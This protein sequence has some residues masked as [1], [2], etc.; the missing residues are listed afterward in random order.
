MCIRDRDYTACGTNGR[1][2]LSGKSVALAATFTYALTPIHVSNVNTS[3]VNLTN[4]VDI[5]RNYD[6]EATALLTTQ[7][8]ANKY[9]AEEIAKKA[10]VVTLTQAEYDALADVDEDTLYLITPL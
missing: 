7:E 5:V 4:P 3:D 8:D 2:I 1:S 6:P 10:S 9:F